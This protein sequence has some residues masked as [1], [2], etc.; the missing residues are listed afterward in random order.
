[1]TI[2]LGLPG[3]EL[4][5]GFTTPVCGGTTNVK[6]AKKNQYVSNGYQNGNN[7]NVS[8]KGNTV[9]INNYDQNSSRGQGCCGNK[10]YFNQARQNMMQA[11][12]MQQISR[13]ISQM[14]A[15][16]SQMFGMMGYNQNSC[17]NNTVPG[18]FQGWC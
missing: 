6:K 7:I 2:G 17:C 14:M 12:F 15:Q 10:G 13:M 11:R 1:M 8:G 3:L 16:F 18:F 5:P 9:V 4:L